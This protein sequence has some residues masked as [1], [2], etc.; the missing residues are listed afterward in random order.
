M[1]IAFDCANCGAHYKTSI[2]SLAGKKIR[3]KRCGMGVHV[4]GDAA[5]KVVAAAPVEPVLADDLMP[6]SVETKPPAKPAPITQRLPN[7]PSSRGSRDDAA[8]PP[9]LDIYGLNEEPSSFKRSAAPGEVVEDIAPPLPRP[10]QY[11]PPAPKKEKTKKGF[12]GPRAS[13]SGGSWRDTEIF[14]GVSIGT[15]ITV[16][17]I[18]WRV[19]RI[20]RPFRAPHADP[21]GAMA[22]ADIN[23]MDDPGDDDEDGVPPGGP[24]AVG[25][26]PG[27]GRAPNGQ[28]PGMPGGLPGGVPNGANNGF[29]P[30]AGA[31]PDGQPP[32]A[33]NQQPGGRFRSA[34]DER[35]RDDG[36]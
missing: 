23:E 17:L 24:G 30:A 18:G 16:S 6:L 15:I 8:T 36:A 25:Q 27:A 7:T 32:G 2:T 21:P 34:E 4:P 19:Y 11:E 1:S 10:G 12:F 31:N 20:T 3:C 35:T 33:A 22:P 14:G 5:P 28:M 26:M 13:S 29:P 9:G